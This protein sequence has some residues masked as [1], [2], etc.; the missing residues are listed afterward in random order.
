MLAIEMFPGA[1]PSSLMSMY[2]S[3]LKQLV[4]GLC[5]A[6]KI[7][8]EFGLISVLLESF[9]AIHVRQSHGLWFSLENSL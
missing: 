9:A 6:L 8:W 2:D 4:L 7:H 5:T 1:L 3:E